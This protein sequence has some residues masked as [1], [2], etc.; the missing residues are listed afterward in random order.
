M[1]PSQPICQ[2]QKYEQMLDRDR[3]PF[4]FPLRRLYEMLNDSPHPHCSAATHVSLGARHQSL[5]KLTY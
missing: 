5:T 3:E 2:M 4:S 1:L